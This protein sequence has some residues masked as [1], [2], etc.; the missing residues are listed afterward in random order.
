MSDIKHNIPEDFIAYARECAALAKKYDF[1]SVAISIR[2][3]FS[4]TW[5]DQVTVNW[6]QGRHGEDSNKINVSSTVHV[7]EKIIPEKARG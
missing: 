4:H 2:P 3:S 6:D 7:Y 1:S 5:R